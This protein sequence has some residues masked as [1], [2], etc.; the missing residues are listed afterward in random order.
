MNV[1][2]IAERLLPKSNINSSAPC[3]VVNSCP[4]L[5]VQI[6]SLFSLYPKY[7]FSHAYCPDW[8]M[9]IFVE[10]IQFIRCVPTNRSCVFND[11][12]QVLVFLYDVILAHDLASKA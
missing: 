8:V 4:V 1:V 12:I 11:K 7:V 2:P 10:I 9:K 6:K 5:F 3:N